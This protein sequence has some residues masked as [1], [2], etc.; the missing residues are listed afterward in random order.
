MVT[1]EFKTIQLDKDERAD[2]V[3]IFDTLRTAGWQVYHV[4]TRTDEPMAMEPG[5]GAR[6]KS[7]ACALD[8]EYAGMCISVGIESIGN[9]EDHELLI[10]C[11]GPYV[12]RHNAAQPN[13]D[14]RK[15]VDVL[16][17]LTTY[18]ERLTPSTYADFGRA[19]LKACDDIEYISNET[20][21]YEFT[22]QDLSSGE[23]PAL[24]RQ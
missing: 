10:H 4:T 16:A 17:V 7:P 12:S 13:D 19:L 9:W 2:L 18:Q 14:Q 8:V 11:C 22:Q 23:L 20:G 6:Y 21:V 24:K 15:L 5:A 1:G 3:L